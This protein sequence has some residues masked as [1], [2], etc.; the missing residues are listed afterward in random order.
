MTAPIKSVR[1]RL[2]GLVEKEFEQQLR[3][4]Y[5]QGVRDGEKRLGEQL[6][7]Q[8][9]ELLE[10]QRGVLASLE[11]TLPQVRSE[12]EQALIDLAFE[13]ARKM[14]ASVE[15]TREMVEAVVAEALSELVAGHSAVVLLN[16]A[17][18]ELLQRVDEPTD[19]PPAGKGMIEFKAS[20]DIARGGCLVQTRFGVLDARRE[21][22][23][24]VLKKTLK[25]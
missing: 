1:L 16:P 14:A 8:R 17:D 21:S 20:G 3:V 4:R 19:L 22:R 6:L 7:Q 2:D 5:E 15:I 24:E 10:L 18:Y 13:A 25:S 12:C 23:L 9:R 11:K